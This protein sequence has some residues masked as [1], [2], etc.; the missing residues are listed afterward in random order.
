MDSLVVARK[1]LDFISISM[2]KIVKQL[3]K[4]DNCYI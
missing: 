2:K 3:V 4:L 1:R